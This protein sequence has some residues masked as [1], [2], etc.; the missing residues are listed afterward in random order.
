MGLEPD[1][2]FFFLLKRVYGKWLQQEP[3]QPWLQLSTLATV[4]FEYKVDLYR[5][6]EAMN[7][8]A[9]AKAATTIN[10]RDGAVKRMSMVAGLGNKFLQHI[11]EVDSI[12]QVVRCFEDNDIIHVNG[13]VDPKSDIDVINLELVCSD[14]DQIEKRLEKLKKGK[15]RDSQSKLKEE[16]EK[17]PLAL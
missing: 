4:I 1:A 3:Q 16:A 12:L 7:P 13:K 14:L 5:Q 11:R 17:S 2:F 8:N 9:Y 10:P 6:G 15:A